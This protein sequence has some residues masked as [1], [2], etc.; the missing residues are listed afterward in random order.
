VLSWLHT[1]ASVPGF[2]GFAV[3]R[4]LWEQPLRDMIAGTIGRSEAVHQIAD[5]YQET[6]NGFVA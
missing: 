3:G 5:R 4:T 1:A 2:D 6:V